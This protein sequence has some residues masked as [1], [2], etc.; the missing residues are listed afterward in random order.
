MEKRED[1]KERKDR[2]ERR[3]KGGSKEENREVE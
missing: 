2:K 1:R 3:K